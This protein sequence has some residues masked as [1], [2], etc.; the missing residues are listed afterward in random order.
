M[1]A[2]IVCSDD[3]RRD[4][5]AHGRDAS[6][7]DRVFAEVERRARVLLQA[8]QSVILDATHVN[9]TYRRYA[10]QLASELGARRVAVWFDLPVADCLERNARRDAGGVDDG[11]GPFFPPSA[12]LV[13]VLAEQFQPPGPDE[14]EEVLSVASEPARGAQSEG[15]FGV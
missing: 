14:F 2:T 11:Q 5:Q 10:V 9:R 4:F 6:D 15:F 8:G 1:R 12:E 3:V 7:T 13:R